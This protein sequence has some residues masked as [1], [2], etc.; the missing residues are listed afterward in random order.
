MTEQGSI[1]DPY[2]TAFEATVTEIGEGE[3]GLVY[4]VLDQTWFYPEGGGQPADRGVIAGLSV[5]DVQRED[6]EIRHWVGEK[7]EVNA[8]DTVACEL[9]WSRRFDYMQQHHAQHLLSAVLDDRFGAPTESVHLGTEECAIEVAREE[10]TEGEVLEAVD[11]VNRWIQENRVITSTVMPLEEAARYP[12]RKRPAVSGDVRLVIVEGVDYNPCGGTHPA[13]TGEVQL[14]HLTGMERA[15]GGLRLTYLAGGRAVARLSELQRI[16]D[17]A[18]RLLN[19]PPEGITDTLNKQIDAHQRLDKQ[20]RSLNEQLLEQ[21]L[22]D[23]LREAVDTKEAVMSFIKEGLGMKELQKLSAKA[24]QAL[25]DRV[26]LFVTV[27]QDENRDSH[28]QF[29][30][31]AGRD[32]HVDLKKFEKDVF[33]LIQGKGGGS[34]V[35]LQGG[36]KTELALETFTN[37]VADLINKDQ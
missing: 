4:L 33:A 27:S 11:Q 8:G 30:L 25:P 31:A 13:R 14:V 21:L 28:L 26:V 24:V 5:T 23:W 12:L 36:G 18:S 10:L 29:V 1:T 7:G 3:N 22:A 32:S 19:S 35:K 15:R 37:Q 20:L 2:K 34:P 9:N 17:D 6:G 16:T